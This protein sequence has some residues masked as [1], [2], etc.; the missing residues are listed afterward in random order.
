VRIYA[1]EKKM[2]EEREDAK[3]REPEGQTY[4]PPLTSADTGSDT[5]DDE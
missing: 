1:V 2:A 4:G 5:P 3:R